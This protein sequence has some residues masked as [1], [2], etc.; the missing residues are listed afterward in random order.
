MITLIILTVLASRIKAA[1]PLVQSVTKY[2]SR[3]NQ[4]C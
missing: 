4:K 1:R 2:F 3:E